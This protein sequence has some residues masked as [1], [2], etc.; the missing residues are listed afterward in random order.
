MPFPSS[1]SVM[2]G[3]TISHYKIFEKLGEG[4][5]CP[6]RSSIIQKYNN[7]ILYVGPSIIKK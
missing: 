5:T 4:G 7:L 6:A 1:G 2:L 3:K